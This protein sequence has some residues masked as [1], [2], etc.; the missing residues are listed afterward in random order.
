MINDIRHAWRLI[1]RMPG[2]AAVVVVSLGIGIGVNTA[3]FSWI[4]TMVLRPIP[5][6]VDATGVQLV[7][8]R[9]DTGSYPG[10]S[11]PEYRDLHDRMRTLPDL[12]AYRMVPFNVGESGRSERTHGLLVSA[13]YFSA[14][15]LTPAVGR[16][17]QA[18]ETARAGGAP[19]VVISYSYW[20]TRFA[21]SPAVL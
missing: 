12:F 13:N 19:V 11:W 15:G 16:F 1:G 10:V 14:L 20:Q 7:E 21:G 4:Q 3:V 8:A 6:V 2:L 9:A 17:L 5:G 18:D